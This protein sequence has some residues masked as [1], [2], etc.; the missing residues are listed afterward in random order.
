MHRV[1]SAVSNAR[2]VGR[3]LNR[4]RTPST[5]HVPAVCTSTAS[6]SK[7]PLFRLH[8][9]AWR[10]SNGMHVQPISFQKRIAFQQHVKTATV[11]TATVVA[12]KE[13]SD[14]AQPS[15]QPQSGFALY[16]AFLDRVGDRIS[17]HFDRCLR[18]A[19]TTS[20]PI[21]RRIWGFLLFLIS[22]IIAYNALLWT[23]RSVIRSI[24]YIF[25]VVTN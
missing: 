8:R 10:R 13:D 25:A 22:F 18:L 11:A 16:D 2:T 6:T 20:N 19:F 1:L 4:V 23:V 7:K 21:Y 14:N 5:W 17:S 12:D 3:S 24:K 9:E 15:K